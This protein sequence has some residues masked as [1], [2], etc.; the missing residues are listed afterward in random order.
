MTRRNFI[1]KSGNSYLA[2]MALGFFPEAPAKTFDL[3]RNEKPNGKKVII[4]GAGLAGLA[5]AYELGKLGYDCVV[6]EARERVGGR[7]WTIRKGTT[8]TELGGEKQ[9][10]Q[11]DEGYYLNAGAA[12]IPHH[13]HLTV[14]YCRELK[15]PVE[16]FGNLNEAGFQYSES[17]RGA[18]ANK[19]VRA[20]EIHA[21]MRGYLTELVA[22]AI[23]Q[24]ALDLEMSKEDVD[25]Y[26]A[27]LR[28]E[29]DLDINK[30]Y[31]GSE[32][33]GYEVAPG[34][35]MRGGTIAK[36]YALKDI[37][38]SGLTHPAFANVGEYTFNQQPVLLQPVGGMDMIPKAF[39]KVVGDKVKR[40]CEIQEIRKTNPGVRIV[41]LDKKTGQKHEV[42]GDY[43]ICALPLPILKGIPSDLSG[44]VQR[45]ADFVPY[46]ETCKIGMQFKR[47]F[48]E[49]D[50]QIFGGI[51]KTN[52][53]ITQIFYP[54]HGMLGPKGVLKGMYNFHGL[55]KKVG[56][57]SIAD[58]QK[59]AFEQGSRIHPQYK[60]EFE[61]AFSLAWHKIPY[62]K[63]GWGIYSDAARQRLYATMTKNDDD[64]YF[65]G[66]HASNLPAWMAGAFE[67]ARYA[68]E[69][70]HKRVSAG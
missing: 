17:N 5:S 24:Q 49:E 15:I 3:A 58:R 70:L 68:V 53:D 34:A 4:L 1:E 69:L 47:R 57:L 25:R 61:N 26:V 2:M 35:G 46:M 59:L 10:C 13:H 36:P 38:E 67:S 51:T 20:R 28:E 56:E 66:E 12:R 14:Q 48:W 60:D 9:I 18:L 16:I 30:K 52:M 33:H 45:V 64:I 54:A 43:C 50:D 42:K 6:L 29:G 65:A 8:E 62:S 22:K 27:W 55:A 23:D 19:R 44:D 63:G 32:R 31:K 7:I 39:E 11:F 41:Y 21:D 40:S 37:V